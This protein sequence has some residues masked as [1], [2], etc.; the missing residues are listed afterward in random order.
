MRFHV[1]AMAT[2]L[3]AALAGCEPAESPAMD[4]GANGNQ[5]YDLTP[6]SRI[7]TRSISFENPTGAV[8]EGGKASSPLGEGRK[9][10]PMRIVMPGESVELAS[11]Q[12]SGTISHIWMTTR[13]DPQILRGAIVRFWW[14]GQEHPSVE[15]PIG[16]FFGFAH[17][18][19][20]AFQSAVHSVGERVG[21]NI[22]L[23]MPFASSARVEFVNESGLPMP[24]FYNIDYTLG[25]AHPDDVG[26]L[27][28]LF[29]RENLTTQ[30]RDFEILPE[31][32]GK[33]RY[34]GSVIGVRPLDGQW[35]GEG[36]FKAFIDGDEDF[37]T[38]AGTGAEDYVGLSYGLQQTPFLYNGANWIEDSPAY[39]VSNGTG[40]ISMY[41]WHI[42]DPF[43]W[44]ESLRLT[45]QQI[46]CCNLEEGATIAGFESY[47][48]ALFEREDDW[49]AAT[50]WYEPIPSAP[51]PEMPDAAARMADLPAAP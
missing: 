34:L 29:Q 14:D 2:L 8:G 23:P 15:A 41:R 11:I 16:D 21:M 28:V 39:D 22:W 46:G 20:D 50:F 25:D 48:N 12:G 35:W 33:G 19:T 9:G 49:S 17:G 10:S 47:M 32:T 3:A 44:A 37:P 38:I 1:A 36:E 51:L 27:H 6:A 4:A 40:R 26:R 30:G 7:K 45:M 42:V 13:N 31:R 18:R 43:Y 5:I 24:L